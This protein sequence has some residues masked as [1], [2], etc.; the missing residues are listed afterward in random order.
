MKKQAIAGKKEAW[1]SMVKEHALAKGAGKIW[2]AILNAI[3][4]KLAYNV[5]DG[6]QLGLRILCWE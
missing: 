4:G 6:S 3:L 2:T 1:W 5:A